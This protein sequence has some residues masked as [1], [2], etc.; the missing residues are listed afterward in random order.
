[1]IR[2]PLRLAAS[3]VLI[4]V[5]FST[6]TARAAVH[7]EFFVAPAGSDANPGTR[8]KP[9]QSPAKARDA[10]REAIPGMKGD[11]VVTFADGEYPVRETVVFGPD[12]SAQGD[13]RIHYRA[14]PGARPVFTGGVRVEG[15]KPGA[16]G[17]WT[18]PLDRAEKL[19]ALY[20]DD[21]RAV[22]ARIAKPINSRGAWGTYEVTANQAPW[23]WRDGKVADGAKYAMTDLPAIASNHRDVEI[24]N[25]TTWNKNFV[26][27]RE[28]TT[29]GDSYIYKLQQPYGA[30]AQNI[31]WGAGFTFGR[32]HTIQNARE[33][34]DEP[35][36]FYFDRSTRTL[37]YMPRPGEDMTRARVIAPVTTTLVNLVGKG[38]HKRVRN[39]TFEGL[40]FAYTD[41]NLHE[42]AGSRGKATVQTNTVNTAYGNGNWHLD[43]YRSYDTLPGA[44]MGSAVEGLVFLRNTIAHTGADG[45]VLTNDISDCRIVGNVIR[46]A[47]GSAISLGHPQHVYENDTPDLKKSA[48]IE[49]EK[50]PAGTEAAPRRV[51]IANNYLPDDSALFP[52][53]CIIN[54][55]FAEDVQILHN[56]IPNAPYTGINIGWGW[57]DFDGSEVAVHPEW[58]KGSRPSVLPGK[59]TTV[60]RNNL[61]RA[62][63]IEQTMSA[64]H[65]GGGIY[66]LGAQPGTVVERNYVRKSERSIYNDEGSAHIVNR[67][68][69]VEGPYKWAHFAPDYGRK[70]SCVV[71]RYFITHNV[72]EVT[73]PGFQV[74]EI[75]VAP[76]AE[77][78][79]KARQI[80]RESGL[81]PEFADIA[82]AK[83]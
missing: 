1:M 44:V 29:E 53:H 51:L 12:D 43:V 50:F 40:T 16:E 80:L 30:I 15:W 42:V 76:R 52:G 35:G 22:M 33:L 31:G 82:P 49:R 75:T 10:V 4:T 11:I 23:A 78:P 69:L 13:H 6:L 28:I 36:E 17:I 8:E 46:D 14:A 38:L 19:R 24:I 79:E 83:P 48:G 34:L 67:D 61:I 45:L 25:Q 71:E 3:A 59:P 68:N 66:T 73:A 21:H 2:H 56:W 18:A 62:N 5:A 70:H 77:W 63:R 54:V 20:V 60:S 41:Y 39:L 58:G 26:C 81:D 57:C 32:N 37:H 47:G 9:F 55:F 64:L 27:V 7:R 65:D 74:R 72:L